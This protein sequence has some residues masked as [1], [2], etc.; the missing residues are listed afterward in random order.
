MTTERATA[1]VWLGGA[2]FELRAVPVPEPAP[3]ELVV[4][5]DLATVCGSDLH[6]VAGRRPSPHPGVLGHEA[7]GRVGRV[8]PGRRDDVQGRPLG[9]GDRVVWGVTA[10]C[11]RCDRCAGGRTAKC[12]A[13]QKVGHEPFDGPWPLSGGY[14]THIV[15]PPGV[16]VARVPAQV[17]DAAAAVAG[18]AIATVMAC[19]EASGEVAGCTLIV[20]GLGMLGL[21]ACSILSERGAAR[22]IGVDPDPGRR[23]TA[24]QMGAHEAIEPSEVAGR[25]AQVGIAAA[26][27]LSGAVD[28]VAAMVAAVDV[29]GRV[30]LAGSV[31]PAGSLAFDPER[32]VRGH[33]HLIGVHNYEPR[34]LLEAVEFLSGPGAKADFGRLVDP[35]VPLGALAAALARPDRTALRASVRPGRGPDHCVV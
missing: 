23:S 6:T 27:E 35:P 26:I 24:L 9:P 8:G 31:A 20:S 3:G 10:S 18:C 22:V 11:G 4:E 1:L 21:A 16:A 34:H 29:G 13:V 12:R 33:L 2:D 7:V 30:V 5:I 25:S 32:I 17:P 19:V 28:A 14:A 15:L